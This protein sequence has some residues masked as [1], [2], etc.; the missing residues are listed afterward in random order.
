MH[1]AVEAMEITDDIYYLL[2][3]YLSTTAAHGADEQSS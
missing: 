1:N 2:Q 3:S